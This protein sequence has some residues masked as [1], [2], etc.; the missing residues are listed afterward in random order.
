MID[1]KTAIEKITNGEFDN[2]FTDIYIDSSMIDYQK[3]RYVHAIE[4]YETIFCPDKVAIFSA[5][6]RSEVCGNHTDHQ[7]GM[8]LATSINLDTI[9]VSAKNNNDV[10]RFVSDGYDMITL[11]INDLEVNDDEAGTTVSLI[12]GVLRGL[13][14]H[15]YKIGGFNAY[16]TSD[17]LIGA[18]LSSSAAFETIIGT[19]VSGLYNDMQISMV[20]I[21]QIG[22]YSENVY[23]GKPSGLMDQTACAVGGLIHIDFKD[24][25]AP[26]VE[27]VDVDFENHACSLCIVDTKGSHQDLTPDYAQIPAD[28]KAIA[29]YFGKEVL[30]DVDEKEFFAAIPVLREKLG[31]RPVLRAMHFFGDNARVAAQVASLREGRFEDFLNMIKASGDSSFKYL[32]NVYTNRDV[33]NQAVS[34]ALAVSENVLGNHGVCRVHGGGFAG[35]IQAFVKN[36]FVEEYRKAL[37][38]VFG[39]GSCHVLKVR[40][41]GGMKVIA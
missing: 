41:Y 19:I 25:K 18:G 37:D 9:A 6:G 24:P 8:V 26:V 3:K 7:H 13:K 28:M 1:T 16:V 31:D 32:Q 38:A 21:A 17:V 22:Q 40:K 35:T 20:E 15:G 12:R 30:R 4:Q 11:N 23:F 10:V 33:Q 29:T 14:D 27:K 34:I 36:D 2:L 39:E 5:P